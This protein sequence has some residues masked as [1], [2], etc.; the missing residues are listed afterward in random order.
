MFVEKTIEEFNA[1]SAEGQTQYLADKRSHEAEQRKAEL[2]AAIAEAQKNNA[3]KDEVEKLQNKL[4]VI[5][6]ELEDLAVAQKAAAE[7]V[8]VGKGVAKTMR[9]ALTEALTAVKDQLDK[10]V[11]GDQREAIKAVITM[12]VDNTIGAGDTQVSITTNTGIISPIRKRELRYLAEVSVGRISGNRAMWIEELDEDGTPIMLG[13][14]DTKTQLSVRYEEQTAN[15]KKIAVYGKVTTEMM[16]DIPQLISYI[17]N[18]LGKRLDIALEDNL[19]NGD[20]LGDNLNGAFDAASSFNAGT[21]AATIPNA[22]DFDVIAAVALQTELNFGVPTGIFV[23]PAVAT[24][25]KLTKGS[26]GHYVLPPFITATGT[27]VAGMR[28]I[29]TTAVSGE[30]FIGG[31]LSVINVLIR[32]DLA[33]QIGLDGNDFINNKKTMLLEKRLVQFVSAND[34]A[35]LIKGDFATAKADLELPVAP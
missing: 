21:L 28:V 6:K 22:N 14:G 11:A 12:G 32:E 23:N 4:T 8:M 26:D 25:M 33:L 35:C 19:F 16:A 24:R 7:K 17:E 29:A 30:D 5:V 13:E 34:K 9:Q 1:L 18:N 10:A 3:S 27:E 2:D 20:G 15:V 31:D